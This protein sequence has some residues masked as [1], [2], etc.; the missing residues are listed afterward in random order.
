MQNQSLPSREVETNIQNIIR[1]LSSDVEPLI[2][3][4][5]SAR[6]APRSPVGH[7][8]A[9]RIPRHKAYPSLLYPL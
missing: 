8:L 1:D 6:A 7:Y 3:K 2:R 5:S 4:A 9:S